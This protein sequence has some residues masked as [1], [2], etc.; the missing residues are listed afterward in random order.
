MLA[1]KENN[2]LILKSEKDKKIFFDALANTP[3]ANNDLKRALAR[4]KQ[5]NLKGL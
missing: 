3:K 4:Y 2:N 1:F 5:K